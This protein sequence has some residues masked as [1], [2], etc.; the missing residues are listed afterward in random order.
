[1]ID[2]NYYKT[3][4]LGDRVDSEVVFKRLL[5]ESMRVLSLYTSNRVQYVEDEEILELIRITLCELI[6][7]QTDIDKMMSMGEVKSMS[8]GKRSVS[9]YTPE[10]LGV[11]NSRSRQ[12]SVVRGNLL[13]T[14][15]LTRSVMR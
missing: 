6:D 8:Q 11:G 1:M 14:G 15:L 4:H 7:V 9:Y 5:T 2:F 13:F 10:E 3:I 12:Y